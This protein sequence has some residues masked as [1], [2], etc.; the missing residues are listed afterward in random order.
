MGDMGGR[1]MWSGGMELRPEVRS[2]MVRSAA[3]TELCESILDA[4]GGWQVPR[5]PGDGL[6]EHLGL[7]AQVGAKLG[8]VAAVGLRRA[9]GC[10]GRIWSMS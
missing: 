10:R 2:S 8:E 1:Q 9:R 5:G 6:A 4:H 3:G 7:V